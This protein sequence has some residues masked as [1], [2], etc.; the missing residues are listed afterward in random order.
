VAAEGREL[1][2]ARG[3]HAVLLQDPGFVQ[4][5]KVRDPAQREQD[6]NDRI[7]YELDEVAVAGDDVRRPAPFGLRAESSDRVLRLEV[8]RIGLREPERVQQ[9]AEEPELLR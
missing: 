8:R 3:R 2:V 9:L 4:D 6:S 5:P 1:G 7:A